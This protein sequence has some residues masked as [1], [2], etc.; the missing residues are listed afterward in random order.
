MENTKIETG[1]VEQVEMK[2]QQ[3]KLQELNDLQLALVGGGIADVV[4]G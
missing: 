2:A 1:A 4:F 3:A